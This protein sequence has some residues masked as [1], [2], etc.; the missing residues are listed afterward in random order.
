MEKSREGVYKKRCK[1]WKATTGPLNKREFEIPA[2]IDVNLQ[3]FVGSKLDQ[4]LL[5]QDRWESGRYQCKVGPCRWRTRTWPQMKKHLCACHG[6]SRIGD[7]EGVQVH[8]GHRL[9]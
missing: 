7:A 9:R 8:G 2:A 6:M 5:S 3:P 1:I 4:S